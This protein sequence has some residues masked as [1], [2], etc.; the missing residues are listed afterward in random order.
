MKSKYLNAAFFMGQCRGKSCQAETA[1]VKPKAYPYIL[2]I[3]YRH[4]CAYE[5]ELKLELPFAFIHKNGF[6]PYYENN[7]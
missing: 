6:A 4:E 3:S 2:S 5:L 1:I 7:I